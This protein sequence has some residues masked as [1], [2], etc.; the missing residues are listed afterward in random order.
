M[1]FQQLENTI[2]H[3]ENMLAAC[4]DA[5]ALASIKSQHKYFIKLQEKALSPEEINR[6]VSRVAE[7]REKY[8]GTVQDNRQKY[9]FK[10]AVAIKEQVHVIGD[11]IES[12]APGQGAIALQVAARRLAG[13]AA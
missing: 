6:R 10:R 8:N 1:N 3:L 9:H 2:K 4:K 7:L 5:V 12:M 13:G 11:L